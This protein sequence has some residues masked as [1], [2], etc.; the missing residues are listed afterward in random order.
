[1]LP[2]TTT[3][4]TGAGAGATCCAVGQQL[5]VGP[6]GEEVAALTGFNIVICDEVDNFFV[7]TRE[8][9]NENNFKKWT[10]S[11]LLREEQAHVHRP[12][13]QTIITVTNDMHYYKKSMLNILFILSAIL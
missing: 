5:E 1:M 10:S 6:S 9:F 11:A 7:Y 2:R 12:L 4:R 13:G 3:W 8:S